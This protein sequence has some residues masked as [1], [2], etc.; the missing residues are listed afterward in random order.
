MSSS[1]ASTPDQSR[2]MPPSTA[3]GTLLVSLISLIHISSGNSPSS[4]DSV[5]RWCCALKT[6]NSRLR[7]SSD[8]SERSF[9]YCYTRV[10]GKKKQCLKKQM[11]I[12]DPV[13]FLT[14][15]VRLLSWDFIQCWSK[16]SFYDERQSQT[17]QMTALMQEDRTKE[18]DVTPT[19]PQS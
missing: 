8:W 11:F 15:I 4:F 17:E 1:V 9:L 2:F 7:L 14:F 10:R 13:F 18:S 3:A 6:I 16:V 19:Q 12:N 5:P